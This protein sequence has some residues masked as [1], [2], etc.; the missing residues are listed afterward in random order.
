[1]ERHNR[2]SKI[3]ITTIFYDSS[4]D[5][6]QPTSANITLSYPDGTVG[7]DWPFDGTAQ[8]TT[9]MALTIVSTI[10][11]TWA[12]TWDSAVSAP[13]IIFWSAVPSNL[14]FSVNE[15]EFLLRGNLANPTAVATTL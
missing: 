1:M 14:T 15:G 5:I 9:T 6:A 7:A 4:L 13:G 2:G 3:P 10:L 11:G 8:K 12:T